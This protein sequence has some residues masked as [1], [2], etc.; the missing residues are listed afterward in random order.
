MRLVALDRGDVRRFEASPVP[1]QDGGDRRPPRR[2]RV[3]ERELARDPPGLLERQALT[4]ADAEDQRDADRALIGAV[5]VVRRGGR[6][7]RRA[8]VVATTA[9]VAGVIGREACWAVAAGRRAARLAGTRA[10]GPRLTGHLSSRRADARSG[11]GCASAQARS[12]SP[13]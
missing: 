1:P 6:A 11:G 4:R 12:R 7:R 3:V 9:A 10:V 2:R 5:A 13:E 8:P